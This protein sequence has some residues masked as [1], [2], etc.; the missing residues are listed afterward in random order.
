M[1]KGLLVVAVQPAHHQDCGHVAAQIALLVNSRT[2]PVAVLWDSAGPRPDTEEDVRGYLRDFG[3]RPARLSQM[4]FIA[5]EFDFFSPWLAEGV[6]H[7]DIL[8]VS[9]HLLAHGLASSADV[10]L[11]EVYGSVHPFFPPEPL[12]VPA[13][14]WPHLAQLDSLAIC[15]GDETR[16][17]EVQLWLGAHGKPAKPLEHLSY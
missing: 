7:H 1:P 16:L 14:P 8:R 13:L 3:A 15:G 11:D 17:L 9:K 12:T 4:R 5:Q 10:D 2:G 6:A